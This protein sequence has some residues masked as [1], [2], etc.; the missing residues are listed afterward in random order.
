MAFSPVYP[1]RNQ[2]INAKKSFIEK[3][4]GNLRN[5]EVSPARAGLP[6]NLSNDY[7]GGQP[8]SCMPIRFKFIGAPLNNFAFFASLR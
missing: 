7:P 5:I 8:R 1:S 2:K 4:F 6:T 3:Q